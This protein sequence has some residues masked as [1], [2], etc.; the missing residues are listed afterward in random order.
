MVKQIVIEDN[1]FNGK[2]L[3]DLKSRSLD[4][5][6]LKSLSDVPLSVLIN[7]KKKNEGENLLLFPQTIGDFGDGL[8]EQCIC[9]IFEKDGDECI[10]T[11][12]LMGYV[13]VN[14][15]HLRIRSRFD[16][17]NGHDGNQD[18]FLLYMLSKILSINI[19]SW[20]YSESEVSCG[21]DFRMFMFANVLHKSIQQGVF[22]A[23]KTFKHNDAK[24]R[25][26]IDVNRHIRENM[27][28]AGRIAYNSRQQD[29]DNSVTQLVRHT[30][31]YMKTKRTGQQILSSKD[32][33][34]DIAIIENVTRSYSPRDRK[35]I[36]QQS[37]RVKSHPYFTEY[38]LLQKLCIQILNHESLSFGENKDNTINGILFDGAWLWEEYL[39]T[40]LRDLDIIH[41]KNKEN[42]GALQLFEEDNDLPYNRSMYPD[43]YSDKLGFVLDA[44][45]KHIDFLIQRE[46]LYQVIAYM[47]TMEYNIG[48]YLY[49]YCPQDTENTEYKDMHTFNLANRT[50]KLLTIPFNIPQGCKTW[51]VYCENMI[52]EE[53]TFLK[54]IINNLVWKQ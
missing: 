25:G 45:Y 13:G 33:L 38:T 18:F 21:L 41:P 28:F 54:K 43:F 30:I 48:G 23:Y 4:I 31:E 9:S 39:N 27:P 22:K 53:N 50:G 1:C 20:K 15:T 5:K 29:F 49:P 36:V 17:N 42:M 46:D 32:V 2:R 37:L 19:F 34:R 3:K 16:L 14:G 26:P 24:V 52:K 11:G 8:G 10:K 40:I 12:N 6:N 51:K 47:H 35:S 7:S 44:K